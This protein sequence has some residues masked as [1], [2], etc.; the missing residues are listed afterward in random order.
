MSSTRSTTI[1]ILTTT[2]VAHALTHV[3]TILHTPVLAHIGGDFELRLEDIA[4]YFTLL[5]ACFGLGS[6][7]AGWLS[8]YRW[9]ARPECGTCKRLPAVV[10]GI[11]NTG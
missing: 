11:E 3:F 10:V 1:K 9:I 6:I 4:I 8:I 2:C 7:P 5:N